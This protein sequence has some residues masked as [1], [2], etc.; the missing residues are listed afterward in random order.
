M[1]EYMDL[2]Y[3]DPVSTGLAVQS[4]T[5]VHGLNAQDARGQREEPLILMP[6]RPWWTPGFG[7]SLNL[8]LKWKS[9][10]SVL[11]TPFHSKI[12]CKCAYLTSC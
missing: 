11:R 7:A 2:R 5:Q 6:A 8:S 3:F 10:V 1:N 9:E 4:P 12:K